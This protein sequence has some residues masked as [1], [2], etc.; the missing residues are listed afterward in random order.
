M[1]YTYK[2]VNTTIKDSA[3]LSKIVVSCSW[4]KQGENENGHTGKCYSK[5]DFD[6][7]QI[8]ASLFVPFD[9]LTEEIVLSWI[10]ISLSET[11]HTYL[12]NC[13]EQDLNSKLFPEMTVT[14]PWE[15]TPPAP[16]S[17]V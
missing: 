15:N 17:I 1:I 16:E 7:T 12:N 8:D 11:D 2:V 9:E 5:T 13:I 14:P 4:Y 6:M 10:E 3:D